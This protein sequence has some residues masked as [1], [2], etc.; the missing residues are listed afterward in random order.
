MHGNQMKLLQ[1]EERTVT[2]MSRTHMK[3]KESKERIKKKR[4]R[5][6]TCMEIK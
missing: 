3:Q 6:M 5:D 2:E 1:E 4:E